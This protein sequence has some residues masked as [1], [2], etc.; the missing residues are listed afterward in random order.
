VNPA[1]YGSDLDVKNLADLFIAQALDVTQH[2]GGTEF[3]WQGREGSS[4][5]VVEVGISQ[6]VGGIRPRTP[7]A[8]GRTLAQTVETNLLPTARTVEEQVGGNP[9]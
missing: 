1:P 4:D 3:R 2:D 9:M 8:F 7:Q 5:I 6:L